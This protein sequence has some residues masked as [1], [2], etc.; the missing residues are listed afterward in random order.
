MLLSIYVQAGLHHSNGEYGSL[1]PLNYWNNTSGFLSSY[2][3]KML[4]FEGIRKSLKKSYSTYFSV[5]L[6]WYAEK[7]NSDYVRNLTVLS[8]E[9]IEF[10][11]ISGFPLSGHW[12]LWILK[13]G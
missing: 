4:P 6:D 12:G 3:L 13:K 2:K 9:I 5:V 1:M 10:D 7:D 8:S 11:C